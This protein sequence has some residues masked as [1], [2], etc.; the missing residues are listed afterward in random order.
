MPL[1][2]QTE[3]QAARETLRLL[4]LCHADRQSNL[5]SW[6][7]LHALDLSVAFLAYSRVLVVSEPEEKTKDILH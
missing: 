4:L 2:L 3:I 1:T 6:L 7:C 5:G